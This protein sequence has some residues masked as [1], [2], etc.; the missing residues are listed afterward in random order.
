MT[1]AVTGAESRYI[2]LWD[3]K[4]E[5]R[6]NDLYTST[7]APVTSIAYGPSHF[8]LL[9]AGFTDGSVRVFDVRSPESRAMVFEGLGGNILD[10]KL[11]GDHQRPLLIAGDSNGVIQFHELRMGSSH[12]R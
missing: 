1:L 4:T 7:D 5:L 2:S 9:C 12:R 3:A 10:C 6:K 11:K 8:G